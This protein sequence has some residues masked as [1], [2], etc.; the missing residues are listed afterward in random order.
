MPKD[1]KRVASWL[2][3]PGIINLI[4]RMVTGQGQGIKRIK[5]Y[6]KQHK[7]HL[8]PGLSTHREFGGVFSN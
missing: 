1:L 8:S 4:L 2:K 5:F 3:I 7:K 6:R